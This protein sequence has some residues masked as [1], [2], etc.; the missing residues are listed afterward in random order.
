MRTIVMSFKP[1]VYERIACGQKIFEHRRTFPDET[2]KV[3]MYVSKPICAVMGILLL[4]KRHS[5]QKW[6]QEFMEDSDAVKRISDFMKSAN[7]A[8]EILEFTETTKISLADLREANINFVV[9][10]MY[11]YID[12]KPVLKFFED[13]LTITGRTIQHIF[14]IIT[15]DIV[16][17]H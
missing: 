15:S 4:G 12:N 7:Y 13:K 8:M 14:D 9:P 16:C 5:L 6:K 3:Y 1:D 11:Y 17:R 10:Q 2:I